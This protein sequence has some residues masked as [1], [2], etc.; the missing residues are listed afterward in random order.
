MVARLER[1]GNRRRGPLLWAL[2]AAFVARLRGDWLR[3]GS[4]LYAAA[5][6]VRYAAQ[7]VV[8]PEWRWLGHTIPVAFHL[9]LASYLF[10][11][12]GAW[13]RQDPVAFVRNPAG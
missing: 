13:R 9:V 3:W 1:L 7:M 5:M 12:S 4:Y 10:V 8:H 2:L 11:L 6:L